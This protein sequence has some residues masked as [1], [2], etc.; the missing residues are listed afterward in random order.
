MDNKIKVA[1]FLWFIGTKR[2]PLGLKWLSRNHKG[3]VG[4]KWEPR[5]WKTQVRFSR[6]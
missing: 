6:D 5:M 1:L 3:P 4:D 2:M